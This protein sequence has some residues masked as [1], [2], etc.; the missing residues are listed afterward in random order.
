MPILHGFAKGVVDLGN[1]RTVPL[2]LLKLP[3]R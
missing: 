3:S 1:F 2:T